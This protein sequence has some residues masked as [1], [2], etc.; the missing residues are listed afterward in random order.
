MTWGQQEA[1][2]PTYIGTIRITLA[3]NDGIAGNH[4]VNFHV[5]VLDQDKDT[6]RELSGDLVPHLTG[7]QKTVLV[8]FLA[9]MRAKAESEILP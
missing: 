6:I 3:D 4:I 8:S 1:K 5:Q 7:P 2:V 9:D